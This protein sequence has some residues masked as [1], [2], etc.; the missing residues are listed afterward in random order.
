MSLERLGVD[1]L[2]RVRRAG[3]PYPD[4]TVYRAGD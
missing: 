2:A 1:E 3:P 4:R